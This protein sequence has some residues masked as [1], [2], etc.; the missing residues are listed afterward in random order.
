MLDTIS[1]ILI[2]VGIFFFALGRVISVVT[3]YFVDI[4]LKEKSDNASEAAKLSGE[5][6]ARYEELKKEYDRL[7]K[8]AK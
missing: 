5:S 8:D 2:G 6:R 1:V 4:N 7:K 3:R